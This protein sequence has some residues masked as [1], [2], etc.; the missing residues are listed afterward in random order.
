MQKR[1]ADQLLNRLD[2]LYTHGNTFISWAELY[3]WYGIERLT[4]G[5]WKDIQSHWAEILDDR[6]EKYLDPLVSEKQGG[7][8][9]FFEPTAKPLSDYTA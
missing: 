2:Q 7:L 1:H 3:Y 8:L 9:F 5:P 6:N 4:K